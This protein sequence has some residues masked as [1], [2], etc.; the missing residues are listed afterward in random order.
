MVTAAARRN[1]EIPLYNDLMNIIWERLVVQW[2]CGPAGDIF[3]TFCDS[4][5]F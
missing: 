3:A 5:T 4:F 2:V 1:G